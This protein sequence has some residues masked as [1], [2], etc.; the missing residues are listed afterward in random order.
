MHNAI[1]TGLV[2]SLGLAWSGSAAGVESWSDPQW[3]PPAG[4]ELWLDASREAA[5]RQS[6]GQPPLAD[7]DRLPVWHDASGWRRHATQAEPARQPTWH[8]VPLLGNATAGQT[9]WT[10]RFD[11]EDDHLRILEVQRRW[12]ACTVLVVA[13]PLSNFGGFRGLLAFH[14]HERRDYET[15]LTIDMNWPATT[16]WRELNLEGRGFGGARNL[17]NT[18]VPF[19]TLHLLEAVIDPQAEE[20]R[21]FFDGELTGKRPFTPQELAAD[22]FTIG[23][24][25]YENGP[26]PQ[27]VQGFLHGDLAEVLVFSRVLSAD[28][29]RQVRDHLMRKHAALKEAL[30]RQLQEARQRDHLEPLETVSNPPPIQML[31]PGFTV[32]ELPVQLTNVNNLRYRPDGKLYALG[33]NGDVWLLSDTDGDELED[34]V[35]RFFENQGRLRGPIGMAV[36][37]RRHP[38]LVAGGD[39]AQGVV[40]AAKGKVSALLDLDGD[41]LAETE[42]ILATGWKE[43]PQN[44]DA[45]GVAIHP[46]DGAIYFGLGTAAYNNPY[47]LNERGQ[48]AYKLSDERGTIQRIEPDGSRRATVCTGVRFTIGMQFHADKELFVTDQ[49]GATW[50]PNGNPFDELLH[51]RPGRHYGFPPRHPHHLPQVFDQPSLFDYG[52]QH[53]STC[54]LAFNEPAARTQPVFG[55]EDWRGQV[56]VCGES[57][58]KLYRT[59]LVRDG[60]GEYVAHNVLLACLSLLTVDVCLSPR[61]DLLVACHSGGP[62]WGTGP[63][64]LGK[65]FRI[66]YAHRELPQPRQVWVAGPQEIHVVFDRPVDPL[67]L[68]DVL[69]QTRLTCGE[70]VAAGD[71]FETLRP[72]YAVTQM[73]LSRPRYKVPVYSA[74]LT[75]DRHT[76]MFA[77]APHQSAV[78]YALTLPGLGRET[79]PAVPGELP[80]QPQVDLAYSLSGVEAVWTPQDAT[81]PVRLVWLP[82]LDLTVSRALTAGLASHAEFWECL[83]QP[84]QLQL[85]TQLDGRG[86]FRPALQPGTQ[87][88]YD[89][90]DD[91][92]LTA[93]A[94]WLTS[95]QP[96]SVSIEGGAMSPATWFEGQYQAAVPWEATREKLVP[97]QLTLATGQPGLKLALAWRAQQGD[98]TVLTGSVGLPRLLLPWA[99]TE[100]NTPAAEER[101]IPELAGGS[102]GRGRRVFFSAEAG[103][104]KCHV[105]H[106]QGGRI[107]VD[108]SNLVHR[109]YASVL[110]DITQ[111]SFAINP[112]YLTYV[113]VLRDGRV[114]TGTV[115]TTGERLV[116][117]DKEGRETT[118][119]REEVE[120]M[121]PSPVSIMPEGLPQKLGPERL[122]DLLTF[123]LIPPP[124]MPRDNPLPPPPPRS[125]HEVARVL[126]DAEPVSASSLRPLRIL[127]VAGPK[128]HGPGEH[129]YPAWQRVWAELLTGAESVTVD[130]AMEWPS[131]DQWTSADTVVFY[132]RGSWNAERAR[133]VDA[134]L[135]RGKG[136]VY[137]HWAVEGGSEAPAFAQRIGL[138]SHAARLR[139]RHGPL[140]LDFSPG[141]DHPVGRHFEKVHFHDESYWQMQ[142]DPN[143]LRVLATGVEDGEPRPL[144]WCFEPGRGR[145]F[146][147]ILGHYSWTFDDPLFRIV[148]LRG[149]AWSAG[150][151]VDRFNELA[152]LGLPLVSEAPAAVTP[153]ALE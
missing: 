68:R 146:V 119:A 49:E 70:Y 54:G 143:R 10:V 57:R 23:A 41:E 130:T 40:V 76:L 65:L 145:V 32:H 101:M 100:L 28:E 33:Y 24:R 29:I 116:I 150:E 19:G 92:W 125:Y 124:R 74:S 127:L 77:T 94:F 14:Q 139:F 152:T 117:G 148:F 73:Q 1:V 52:P 37:P 136:L 138:A 9:A 62:D 129:D 83:Q 133:A 42:R 104:S 45:V 25:Y 72:G 67:F 27:R 2:L 120:Q 31:V 58:G 113:V 88:D 141:R 80:Q 64:G 17:M 21:L 91:R 34:H 51:I 109:D 151:A 108:L 135:A 79:V 98:G 8:A 60:H 131:V 5:A 103:C 86:L 90:Q 78:Q 55:P 142:G 121:Q 26:G 3:T 13:A 126:A 112:D 85:A 140:N 84:G 22:A 16:D 149:L 132:Q 99:T 82:H 128:D 107:G 6:E 95:S 46:D 11:G 110:R 118:I 53:Q 12:T 15:G 75:T 38:L 59:Q 137:L 114:L 105:M 63:T 71:R 39:Q 93:R 4:L 66:R 106:G 111:P 30:P 69:R 147:S 50:L 96:F 20:V 134:H 48:A 123:L 18:S 122:K 153:Q 102:W 43:I 115:R 89:P 144:F 35:H 36:I 87:L 44:V 81:Q 47:L 7:G 56:F 61:G 97:V